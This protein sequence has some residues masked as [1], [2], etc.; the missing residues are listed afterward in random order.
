MCDQKKRRNTQKFNY[1]YNFRERAKPQHAPEIK[2][3]KT[4]V[5]LPRQHDVRAFS[6]RGV[7]ENGDSNDRDAELCLTA[8]KKESEGVTRQ[9]QYTQARNSVPPASHV[10]NVDHRAFLKISI[11]ALTTTRPQCLLHPVFFFCFTNINMSRA[12]PSSLL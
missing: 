8:S 5:F 7:A 6:I 11:K 2:K 10:V 4:Q 12:S 1:K 3:K 9:R